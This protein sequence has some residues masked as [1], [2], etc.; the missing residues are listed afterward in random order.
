MGLFYDIIMK[1]GNYEAVTV[2]LN[3]ADTHSESKTETK[4]QET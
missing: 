3:D 1:Q 4:E 2:I